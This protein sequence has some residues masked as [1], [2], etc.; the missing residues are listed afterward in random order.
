MLSLHALNLVAVVALAF[1][2]PKRARGLV[3][4]LGATSHSI[5]EAEARD[6]VFRLKPLGTCLSR[7][8][9]IA[10]R[11]PNAEVVIGVRRDSDVRAHAWVELA[12][13][14]LVESEVIGVEL[15]RL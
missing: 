3:G 5:D 15:A 8:L 10:A 12:G 13:K 14:P 2:K 6:A 7:S 4:R 1:L 9:A 11:L